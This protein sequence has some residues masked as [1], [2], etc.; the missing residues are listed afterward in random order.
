MWPFRKREKV[1]DTPKVENTN[2]P[3]PVAIKQWINCGIV[4]KHKTR[5]FIGINYGF[6]GYMDYYVFECQDCA[7]KIMKTAGQL[8]PT[9]RNALIQLGYTRLQKDK[10]NA[11]T[12]RNSKKTRTSKGYTT[13]NTGSF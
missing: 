1:D 9:E 8:S 5:R 11:K 7:F 10:K 13:A 12:T 6:F 2:E 4:S 3:D